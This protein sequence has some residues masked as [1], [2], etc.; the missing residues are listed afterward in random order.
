MTTNFPTSL[1]TLT[2]PSATD[3]VTSPS[4]ADQHANANDAIEALEAKVGVDSSAVTTSHDYKLSEVTSTD[5][6]VGKTATQTLSNKTLT[7][8][9]FADLGFI[10]DAN[11]NELIV[12]DTVTTA[13]NELKIANAATGGNPE[14][15]AQGGDSDVGIDLQ[16][17]G[18]GKYRFKGT[19]SA[20][21]EIQL[22]EDTDNGS[23]YTGFKSPSS[24]SANLDYTLP[25]TVG[26]DGQFLQ[27]SSSSGKTLAW[28]SASGSSVLTL[29]PK[30]AITSDNVSASKTLNS[31]TTA[32]VGQI[33]VPFN[34]TVNKVSI[35]VGTVNVAGTL[36]ISL[37]TED[38]Q[39]QV[40]SVTT[41]SISASNT[42]VTTAVAGVTVS[43]GIYYLV[44]NPNSTADISVSVWSVVNAPFG[45]TESL[46]SDVSSEP[47]MQGTLTITADTPPTNFT[48]S[49]ITEVTNSTVVIRLD[50]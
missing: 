11:G 1:D 14:I 20:A 9:K 5:K 48:P 2:N 35:R 30:S 25:S 26:S 13:V 27:L 28:A 34:I 22:F 40:F 7:A 49:S 33:V 36:D 31:S 17:K 23:N 29:I 32:T 47:V 41:A 19:S 37:Y 39:T 21:A 46:A 42:V 3:A 38:G 18:S 4:H 6:A 12:M 44:V 43:A 10:A 24:L 15:A 45:T 16:A 8:P 50:N